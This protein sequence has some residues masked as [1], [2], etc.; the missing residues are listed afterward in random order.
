VDFGERIRRAGG[1]W[2]LE[3]VWH[4]GA[5]GLKVPLGV[6]ARRPTPKPVVEKMCYAFDQWRRQQFSPWYS[7]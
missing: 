1:G 2:L 3:D 7:L 6:A 5:L 4:S